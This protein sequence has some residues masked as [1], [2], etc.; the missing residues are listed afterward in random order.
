MLLLAEEGTL[1]SHVWIKRAALCLFRLICPNAAKSP[2]ER[3]DNQNVMAPVDTGKQ[4][5]SNEFRVYTVNCFNFTASHWPMALY[6]RLIGLKL[7]AGIYTAS[8]LRKHRYT[9]LVRN[10]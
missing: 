3:L 2:H 7:K 8:A 5:L 4:S 1:P 10:Y 6:L 9:K